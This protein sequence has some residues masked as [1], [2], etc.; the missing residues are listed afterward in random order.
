MHLYVCMDKRFWTRQERVRIMNAILSWIREANKRN[1]LV[2]K[3]KLIAN[4]Q[5]EFG[6]SKN[7][8]KEY[9][10]IL[11]SIG[12]IQIEG[13]IITLSETDEERKREA[14]KEFD[15]QL[16]NLMGGINEG[17]NKSS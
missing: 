6:T 9:V 15:T 7:K 11:E 2:S 3:K 14:E 10:E 8:A 4:I 1:V 16:N 12:K 13:D 17:E 5:Y